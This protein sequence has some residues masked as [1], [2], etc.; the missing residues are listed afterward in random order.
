MHGHPQSRNRSGALAAALILAV[1][2]PLHLTGQEATAKDSAARE[3]WFHHVKSPALI[4]SAAGAKLC[5]WIENAL[6]AGGPLPALPEI[7][8]DR[9]GASV[10]VVSWSD[11][12][13]PA[14]VRI[15]TGGSIGEAT[16]DAVRR[17]R[18]TPESPINALLVRLDIV[19]NMWQHPGFRIRQTEVPA[20]G[21][22]GVAFS[23]K[24]GLGF[25]P[26]ELIA[27][28]AVDAQRRLLP[29]RIEL[30]LARRN[31]WRNLGHWNIIGNY[32]E[33]QPACFFECQTFFLNDDKPSYVFRGHRMLQPLT[34]QDLRQRT[35]AGAEHMIETLRRAPADLLLRDLIRPDDTPPK[36][37]LRLADWVGCALALNDFAQ[38]ADHDAAR[39]LAI[40]IHDPVLEF[41][42]KPPGIPQ[43]VLC[44]A[45]GGAIRIGVNAL[46]ALAFLQSGTE[47]ARRNAERIGGYILAQAT[48]DHHFII[49]RDAA[50]GKAVPNTSVAET[51]Q[52]ILALL[53][54]YETTSEPRY[55][56]TAMQALDTLLE[57]HVERREMTDLPRSLWVMEALN[58]AYTFTYD[59]RRAYRQ[60]AQRIALASVA[61][62]TLDAGVPDETFSPR[63]SP[64]ATQA[65]INAHLLSTAAD[66]LRAARRDQ[67]LGEL[68][69]AIHGYLMFQLQAQLDAV[70]TVF[71]PEPRRLTG[72]FRDDAVVIRFRPVDQWV[73]LR[74]LVA[75]QREFERAG[76]PVDPGTPLPLSRPQ[77][78]AVVQA[79]RAI[80]TFPRALP[81]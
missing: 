75:A 26:A 69:Q 32:I 51:A 7:R 62:Q 12:N 52:A 37:D 67:A 40:A 21:L 31:Q 81:Q 16:G 39:E 49:H 48:A 15:G 4:T 19:Q 53:R 9:R 57:E 10:V 1:A 44:L 73:Q 29:S 68:H 30:L 23:P 8:G 78:Q 76:T 60:A 28:D 56:Q 41:A 65:A 77:K 43:R 55:R 27:V 3:I 6:E 11:G 66:I 24:S 5:R 25:L 64:S 42:A 14:S 18:S 59:R 70:A 33:P 35:Q 61:D 22:C 47:D 36:P 80:T 71:L 17:H 46:A 20:P 50:T 34:A 54:L 63:N 2:L 58:A 72:A 38:F 74:A 13:R 45:E 79:Y